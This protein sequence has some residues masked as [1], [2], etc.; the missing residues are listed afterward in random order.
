MY[1]HLSILVWCVKNQDVKDKIPCSV[2]ILTFNSEGSLER[3]LKTASSFKEIIICDGGSHDRTLEIAHN[4]GCKILAQDPKFKNNE[5]RIVDFSGVRNQTLNASSFDWYF[6]LDSDEYLSEEIIEE[7]REIVSSNVPPALYWVPRKYVIDGKIIECASTY[8]SRQIRFFN[9]K[10]VT[11]F[12]KTIHERIN[13]IASAEIRL[14]KNFMYVPLDNDPKKIRAKWNYY[15]GLEMDRAGNVTFG[16]CLTSTFENFKISV[17]FLYRFLR[18]YFFCS[19]QKMPWR[20]ELE[21]HVYH[22]NLTIG[23]YKKYF[24][25]LSK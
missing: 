22:Y 19:G 4:Y 8:P 18:N 6:Y 16:R 3:A 10:V 5:G 23:L 21:R 9:R 15:V 12:I 7:I 11:N 20:I 1:G 13:P 25:L 24:N 14:L 17:L 2:A